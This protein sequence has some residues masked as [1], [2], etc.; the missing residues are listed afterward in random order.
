MLSFHERF[1]KAPIIPLTIS[2]RSTQAI[3]T[4]AQAVIEKNDERLVGVIPGLTKNLTAFTKEQGPE[5]TLLRSASDTAEP[6]LVADII[7]D[8]V[9][10]GIDA[11]EIAV[12]TQTN[13]ELFPLYDVLRSRNIPVLL[14]GKADLMAHPLVVEALAIMRALL[15][16]QSDAL[17]S[18]ALASSAFGTHPADISRLL[19]LARDSKKRLHDVLVDLEHSDAPFLKKEELINARD[20]VLELAYALETRTVLETVERVLH[21]LSNLP[22]DPLDLA[23]IEAFFAYTKEQ[24]LK[25]SSQNYRGFMHDIEFY[26]DP[27]FGQARLTYTL[28][29][30]VTEGVQLM[31]AHQSKGLEF[32]TVILTNFRDGHWDKRRKPGSVSI[33]EEILFGWSSD[34]KKFEQHQDERRVGFVA[35]TRAKRELIFTCPKEVSVGEKHKP[36]S[37]S[38]FFAEA[39]TLPESEAALKNPEQAS[40]LL[41][42][43]VRVLDKELEAYVKER[44]ENFSLSATSLAR[45]IRDP[46]EFL[47]MDLLGQPEHFTE[48]AIRRLGYGSAVHWALKEWGIAQKEKKEFDEKKFLEA[49][50]WYLN[51][52]TILSEKQREDL[53]SLAGAALPSYYS[54]RLSEHSPIIYSLER[55]YRGRL[56]DIPLKGKIDRIDLLSANGGD[57]TVIDY[58]TGAAKTERE[59]RGGIEPGTIS[60]IDEGQNFRQLTF[61]A[62]L[63]EKAD[64][65]IR[66]VS[67]ALE[68]IGERGEE[69]ERVEL[70]V[71]EAEKKALES[72]IGDVWTKIQALD[73]TPLES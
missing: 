31:T 24:C 25:K 44:L 32:H 66:P 46:Q 15:H 42:R 10:Q 62:L 48:G 56:G 30:L 50:T 61:Y 18:S 2:Y 29:H 72:L 6:W 19:L 60:R 52:K 43:P 69:P 64:P 3:L 9:K 65:L 73:F 33:P 20:T 53:L 11:K 59:I 47:E 63:L 8:R 37:P 36:V 68:F 38:A 16:T 1:P 22:R 57:V 51:E 28:P 67:F 49:F 5:P 4:A 14:R 35:M 58:K 71:Q 7:E 54:Q 21:L 45:F 27:E 17:L 55:D 39:G 41:L 70:V 23:A 13:N 40:T 12:L 26:A 34:Q